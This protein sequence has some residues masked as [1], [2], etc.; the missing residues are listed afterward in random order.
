MKLITHNLLICPLPSCSRSVAL[1]IKKAQLIEITKTI[2]PELLTMLVKKIDFA[3]LRGALK[4]LR[5]T[6]DIPNGVEAKRLSYHTD[7]ELMKIL[8]HVLL[9]L[10]IEEG[11]LYCTEC[12][13]TFLIENGI[14]NL[15]VS[16]ETPTGTNNK[17]DEL[18]QDVEF[19]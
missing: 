12:E 8:H 9:E 15:K 14:P 4:D 13:S 5:I 7:K 2:E 18:N 1:S 11:E 17:M 6:D 10:D 16:M 19:I 3:V